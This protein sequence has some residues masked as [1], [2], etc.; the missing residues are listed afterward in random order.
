MDVWLADLATGVFTPLT[1]YKGFESDPA[2]SP[3]E[4]RIAYL[5][6]QDGHRLPFA[7]DLITGGED[8]VVDNDEDIAVDDWSA[9]GRFLIVRE[10]RRSV[11][12]LSMTGEAT[13]RRLMAMP[14]P[15]D[16]SQISPDGHWIAFQSVE[17]DPNVYV[18]EFPSFSGKRQVSIAGGSQPRWRGDGKELFYL[19]ADNMMMSVEVRSGTFATPRPLFQA[20]RA[21]MDG[22][23]QYDVTADGQRFLMVQPIQSAREAF[24]F[25]LNWLPPES[26]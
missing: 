20:A 26:K 21:R 8:R 18:A 19:G 24:T 9:D 22:V 13:L 7:K 16:Q 2:W 4:R 14:A 25:L 11:S 1:D 23:S 5:S 3:D 6:D 15:T 10:R 12:A 17:L